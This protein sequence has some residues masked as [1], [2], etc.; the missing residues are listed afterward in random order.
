VPVGLPVVPSNPTI[1]VPQICCTNSSFHDDKGTTHCLSPNVPYQAP[2]NNPNNKLFA[3]IS[4][5]QEKME[6]QAYGDSVFDSPDF[7]MI[8]KDY[9][10]VIGLQVYIYTCLLDKYENV[11]KNIQYL[12][13]RTHFKRK[14]ARSLRQSRRVLCHVNNLFHTYAPSLR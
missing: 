9:E 4:E 8:F 14:Y 13:L 2:R 1:K 3:P 12:G 10:K 11:C 7:P 5:E 6:R